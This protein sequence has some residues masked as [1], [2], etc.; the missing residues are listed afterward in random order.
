L[1]SSGFIDGRRLSAP[2][3]LT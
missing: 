3:R 2:V 1:L